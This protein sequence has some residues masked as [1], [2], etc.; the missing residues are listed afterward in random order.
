M[1]SAYATGTWRWLAALPVVA[2]GGVLCR[3]TVAAQVQQPGRERPRRPRARLFPALLGGRSRPG[4]SGRKIA[5][6]FGADSDADALGNG[7]WNW[8][9]DAYVIRTSTATRSGWL[10]LSVLVGLH[11]SFL[12]GT[13]RA[14]VLFPMCV[15]GSVLLPRAV[16]SEDEN[17]RRHAEIAQRLEREVRSNIPTRMMGGFCTL[18]GLRMPAA[19]TGARRHDSRRLACSVNRYRAVAPFSIIREHLGASRLPSLRS[20]LR[21]LDPPG[22]LPGD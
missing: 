8:A 5:D 3:P 11:H 18:E 21:G 10:S 19:K 20:A 9:G 14:T 7:A 6:G 17:R 2:I 22:A 1:R 15:G 13:F 12:V 16:K 4:C